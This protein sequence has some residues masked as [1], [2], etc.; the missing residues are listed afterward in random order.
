[1]FKFSYN[2]NGLR[3][4]NPIKAVKEV[5]F[6]GYDGIEIALNK[7]WMNPDNMS[8]KNIKILRN[9]MSDCN[10][11][12]AAL[13]TGEKNLLS[14]V[15]HEPSLI[16]PDRVKRH[17]R[18][19]LLKQSEK[20]AQ[21][22]GIDKIGFASGFKN[23]EMSEDEAWTHLIEGINECLKKSSDMILMIEPEPGMFIET[24]DQAIK[25]IEE[26]SDQRLALNLDIGHVVC[27]EDDHLA[28]IKNACRY[29][30]HMHI[31]DIAGRVHKHLIPGTGDID[32]EGLFSVLIEEDYQGF[33]S[34][35]LYD[36]ASV[37]VTALRESIQFFDR[38][39]VKK[40]KMTRRRS[41]LR[42][43]KAGNLGTA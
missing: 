43:E 3:Y 1:M 37:Y 41:S 4:I 20:L 10:V 24:T 39:L 15:D 31:E 35:E 2:T 11:E 36:H 33:V 16:C 27:C 29:T 14:N 38:L 19:N 8:K 32:F 30:K 13:A 34:V 9:F 21:N 42:Y 17:K 22:L 25:L 6:F 40:F 26:I 18:I 23:K 12:P 28:K 7:S 5:A